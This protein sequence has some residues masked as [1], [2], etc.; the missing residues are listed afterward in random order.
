MDKKLAKCIEFMRM[1]L[2]DIQGAPFLGNDFS[3][4]LYTIWYEH[5]QRDAASAYEFLDENFSDQDKITSALD[6]LLG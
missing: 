4:E 2:S 3:Q 6:K 5:A 1:L